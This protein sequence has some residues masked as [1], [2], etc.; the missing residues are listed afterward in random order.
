M[1]RSSHRYIKMFSLL[2]SKDLHRDISSYFFLRSQS[3]VLNHEE[4][5]VKAVDLESYM[6]HYCV[7][8]ILYQLLA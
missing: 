8:F 2:A 4:V 1:I 5:T 6:C 7:Y 3:R